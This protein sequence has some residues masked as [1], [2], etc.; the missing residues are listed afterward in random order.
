MFIYIISSSKCE[1]CVLKF[2]LHSECKKNIYLAVFPFKL[3]AGIIYPKLCYICEQ[4]VELAV[5]SCIMT[6]CPSNA[7]FYR[8]I[9]LVIPPSSNKLSSLN[10]HSRGKFTCMEHHSA[11]IYV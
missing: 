11:E 10:F 1:E 7:T 2:M 8:Y 9:Q 5:V 6:K 3:T 4:I